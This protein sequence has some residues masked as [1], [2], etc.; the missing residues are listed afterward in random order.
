[1]DGTPQAGTSRGGHPIAVAPGDVGNPKQG[2]LRSWGGGDPQVEAPRG[3]GS[4]RCDSWSLEPLGLEV[5]LLD[6]FS[7]EDAALPYTFYKTYGG[8]T[9]TFEA[10]AFPG[11]FL[12][13]AAQPDQE[14]G[15]APRAAPGSITS[16]Y[17]RRR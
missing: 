16:F 17:L 15:L 8:T 5:K 13:T 3:G 4:L 12:S 7:S 2:I 9:H 10:A 1:H 14:L 6:L 11:H